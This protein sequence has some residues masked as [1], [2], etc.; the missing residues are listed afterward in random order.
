MIAACA[1][2]RHVCGARLMVFPISQKT[3]PVATV[4]VYGFPSFLFEDM[5]A[6]K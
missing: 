5:E 6:K 1:L 3:L 4:T 2:T